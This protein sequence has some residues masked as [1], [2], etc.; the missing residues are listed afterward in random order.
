V[1]GVANVESHPNSLSHVKIKVTIL[2]F[3]QPL[4]ALLSRVGKNQMNT[5]KDQENEA[6]ISAKPPEA[7]P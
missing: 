5:R 7:R 1:G 6:Y 4:V 3:C 2:L